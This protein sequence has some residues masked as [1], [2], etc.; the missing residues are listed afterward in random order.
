[1]GKSCIMLQFLERKFKFDHDTTIGVEFGSKVITVAEQPVKL[2]VW[3]TVSCMGVRPAR[4][5]SSP[6]RGPTTGAPSG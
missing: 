1:M 4:R 2:Q 5:P 3:D 6:S